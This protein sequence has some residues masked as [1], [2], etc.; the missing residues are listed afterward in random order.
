MP[1]PEFL[2]SFV[3]FSRFLKLSKKSLLSLVRPSFLFILSFLRLSPATFGAPAP[4]L[5]FLYLE[6]ARARSPRPSFFGGPNS[7]SSP[8]FFVSNSNSADFPLWLGKGARSPLAPLQS[9]SSSV[10]FVLQRQSWSSYRAWG[11]GDQSFSLAARLIAICATKEAKFNNSIMA[12]A[13]G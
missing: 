11:I 4:P 1:F 12:V 8:I 5:T 7:I 9:Q 10:V 13:I 6:C 3:R 2:R